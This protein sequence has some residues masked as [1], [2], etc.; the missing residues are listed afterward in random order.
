MV[1]CRKYYLVTN[2]FFR[3]CLFN[4]A[5]LY[6]CE[7]ITHVRWAKLINKTKKFLLYFGWVRNY[8]SCNSKGKVE[9]VNYIFNNY[10]KC[11]QHELEMY[12]I[13]NSEFNKCSCPTDIIRRHILQI[14]MLFRFIFC[15]YCM[16]RHK[17]YKLATSIIVIL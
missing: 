4:R 13:F 17:K 8:M 16:S 10:L 11:L 3:K 9:V 1:R 2:I 14:T 12:V 5:L 15:S 6:K 7:I